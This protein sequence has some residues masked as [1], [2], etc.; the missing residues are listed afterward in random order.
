MGLVVVEF[1]PSLGI[2]ATCKWI[3]AAAKPV[4]MH[5]LMPLNGTTTT[6]VITASSTSVSH[7]GVTIAFVIAGL[8][9]VILDSVGRRMIVVV[10]ALLVA[11]V[12]VIRCLLL[13]FILVM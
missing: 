5:G 9:V 1:L 4:V 8:L 7:R 2:I 6:V 12:L 3:K 10:S 11:L 13:S